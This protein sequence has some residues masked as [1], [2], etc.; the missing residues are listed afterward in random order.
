MENT[1]ENY[2][3]NKDLVVNSY[4]FHAMGVEAIGNPS[5][6]D[7]EAAFQFA[8]RSE[9]SVQFWVGDLIKAV[10][11]APYSDKYTQA[12]DATD[13][14]LRTL[15]NNKYVA[16]KVPLENR[17]IGL[18]FEH[19]KAVAALDAPKQKEWLD[20]AEEEGW[21]VSE[22]KKELSSTPKAVSNQK[23]ALID[24]EIAAKKY[25]EAVGMAREDLGIVIN[26]GHLKYL[27]NGKFEKADEKY[28]EFMF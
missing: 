20:K 9:Q 14:S 17:H 7:W 21:T 3:S 8:K 4:K 18:S 5:Y 24:L 26:D 28:L 13:Y 2:Q 27:K 25:C 22:M 16:S 11:N 12:L 6:E 10:E 23:Q 15:Q 1:I 19:H